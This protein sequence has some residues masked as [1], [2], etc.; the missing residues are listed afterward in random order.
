M[1]PKQICREIK[2]YTEFRV[3]KEAVDELTKFLEYFIKE[4]VKKSEKI[5]ELT[6]RK[7]IDDG[8]IKFA[9]GEVIKKEYKEIKKKEYPF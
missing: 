6:Y 9:I 5:S 7:T 8:V 1:N 2:K 4:I 3:K